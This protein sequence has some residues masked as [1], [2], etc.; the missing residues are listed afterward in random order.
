[1]IELLFLTE[2]QGILVLMVDF[3]ST[4]LRVEPRVEGSAR[5][6]LHLTIIPPV[7]LTTM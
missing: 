5:A 7:V 6:L 3:M 4:I 1:M 2:E